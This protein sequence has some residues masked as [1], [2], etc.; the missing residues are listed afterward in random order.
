MH[1]ARSLALALSIAARSGSSRRRT[2]IA[3]VLGGLVGAILLYLSAH[4]LDFGAVEGSLAQARPRDVTAA[5]AFMAAVYILQAERWRWIA[6]SFAP[7]GRL[8]FLSFVI[9][10]VA[11]NNV[12]PG[13]PGD[14]M[15]AHWL[16]SAAGIRRTSAL[17]TVVLDRAGDL[18]ALALFLFAGYPLTRHPTWLTH[19]YIGS[20]FVIGSV[21]ILVVAGWALGRRP[22]TMN[23]RN[24][25]LRAFIVVLAIATRPR[26]GLPALLL[27]LSVWAAWAVA[28]WFCAHA[29]GIGLSPAEAVFVTALMNLGT[30]I[31]SSPGFVGTYQW[32]GIAALGLFGVAP[33]EAFAFALLLQA[34]WYVPTTLVG[35]ALLVRHTIK[36]A[37]IPTESSQ[38]A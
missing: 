2:L 8:P 25:R 12:L 36:W 14:F 10:G 28:A 22:G 33:T 26:N 19:F 11:C 17:A 18:L 30:A 35:L 24:G 15:R 20:A 9:G 5:V 13:R 31:P 7:L 27:S 34:V 37:L 38:P 21:V 23:L 32:L 3:L 6:R 1:P 29:L 4:K 16:S